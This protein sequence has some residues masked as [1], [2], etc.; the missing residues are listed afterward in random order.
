MDVIV[1]PRKGGEE[2]VVKKETIEF[3]EKH[4]D[5]L[6]LVERHG[7]PELKKVVMAIKLAVEDAKR[8]G[9]LDD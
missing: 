8:K 6:E 3:V 7:S 2:E 9:F 4:K 1:A 5:L